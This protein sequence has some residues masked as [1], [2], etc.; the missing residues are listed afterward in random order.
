MSLS[1]LLT[2]AV[3]VLLAS[4]GYRPMYGGSEGEV[5][6][7]QLSQIKINTI[8]DRH[9]QKLHNLLLDRINPRGRPDNPLYT[10]D[11][12]TQISTTELGLRFTEI[13]TRA[14]LTLQATYALIDNRTGETLVSG[15][16]RSINSYNIPDSEYAKVTAEQD[17]TDR[18]ARE[19][20]DEIRS[21]LSLHFRK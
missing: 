20:S 3:V 1:R 13:A 9:G 14:Q 5:V 16:S 2:V 7:E 19:I 21:R 8:E 10:L 6:V 17:A 18:A 11:V 12:Q 4:C 15:Y